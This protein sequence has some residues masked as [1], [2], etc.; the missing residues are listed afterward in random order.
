ME[1]HLQ[2]CQILAKSAEAMLLFSWTDNLKFTPDDF[3]QKRSQMIFFR[4]KCH[5]NSSSFIFSYSMI[6]FF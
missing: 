6:R 2:V 4:K 1:F 5:Q 3:E